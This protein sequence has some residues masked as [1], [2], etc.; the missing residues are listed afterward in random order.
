MKENY[1]TLKKAKSRR[2]TTETTTVTDYADDITLHANTP[3]QAESLLHSLEQT[4]GGLGLNVNADK[5]E[6]M[7]FN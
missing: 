6:Y 4:A 3:T 5:M 1:F 2:Y 7:C